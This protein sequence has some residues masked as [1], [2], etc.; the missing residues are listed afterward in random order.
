MR[1]VPLSC[2]RLLLLSLIV[3]SPFVARLASAEPPTID[4]ATL[5][6]EVG[7]THPSRAIAKARIEAARAELAAAQA[8]PDPSLSIERE[9]PYLDG[10]GVATNYVRLTVPF[11]VSGQRGREVK[12]AKTDVLAATNEATHYELEIVLDALR[13]FDDAAHARLHVEQLTAARTELVRAVSIA[14]ERGKAGEASGYQVQ[15]FEVELASHDDDLTTAR[16]ELTRLRSRLA[17]IAGRPG[18]L[19]AAAPLDLP[20]SIPSLETL[21]AKGNARID[22]RATQ[23]RAEAA[24]QRV[25]AGERGWV[26]QPALTIGAMTA[27]LGD[28]T[29]TGYVAGLSLTIPVFDRGKADR[30]R[31]NAER[32]AAIATTRVLEREIPSAV[33]LA[34]STLAARID[35][36]RQLETGQL[37]RLDVI[38]R[39][40][41]TAFREGGASA[42][43]LLDAHRAVRAVRA[44]ALQLRHQVARDKRELE[45]AVGQRL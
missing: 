43:E 12:A 38:L 36:V 13:V 24:R 34:H 6:S 8:R 35:Q 4:E 27:D 16:I 17:T 18:E 40:A 14:R 5:V 45:L 39:A 26:P 10:R 37:A 28:R 41:E 33:R 32:Q 2:L 15:R 22:L 31:A 7:A 1:S 19:D 25:S 29:G 21:L 3:G 42:V 23:L 20:A 9:E 11:E 30:A 44:R